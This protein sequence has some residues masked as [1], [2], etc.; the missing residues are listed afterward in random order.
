MIREPTIL[1]F[2]SISC[3]L[4]R[5]GNSTCDSPVTTSGYSNPKITVVTKVNHS[6]MSRFFFINSSNNSKIRQQYVDEFDSEKRCNNSTHSVDQQI[7]LQQGRCA[8]WTV[9]HPA[10]CQRDECNDNQGVENYC[11]EDGRFRRVQMHYVQDAQDG[12]GR[13]KHRGYNCEVLGNVVGHR[14][15]R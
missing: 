5:S 13:G 4:A 9:T 6:E 12:K 3:P 2:F 14:E 10:E 11:R 7:A 1:P 15:R 8:E